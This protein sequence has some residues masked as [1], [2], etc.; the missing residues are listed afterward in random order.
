MAPSS[1]RRPIALQRIAASLLW[2]PAVVAL[3]AAAVGRIGF[4]PTDEGMVLAYANR[5]LAGQ[6]PHRDFITPRPV[7]ASLLHIVDLFAPAPLVIRSHVIALAEMTAIAILCG[8]LVFRAV[9][10]R[11]TLP[12]TSLVLAVLVV[13]IHTFP[14][15]EWSTVDGVLL[16]LVGL[17]LLR[18]VSGA[19]PGRTRRWSGLLVAGAA[20]TMKQSF[21]LAPILAAAVAS[22]PELS[23]GR[24]A[25]FRRLLCSGVIAATPAAMYVG[26]L[27]ALGAGPAMATQLL[28][29]RQIDPLAVLGPDAL[30]RI[31]LLAG[32][33]AAAVLGIRWIRRTHPGW[34]P[35]VR[36]AGAIAELVSCLLILAAGRLSIAGDWG[37]ELVQLLLVSTV[38][39]VLAGGRIN[40][41]AI[42][43]GAIAWMTTLSY[44]YNNADLV[45]G[46]VALVVT[47]RAATSLASS[48][49]NWVL[50]VGWRRMTAG[51]AIAAVSVAAA[52]AARTHEVYR[53][54][55][56]AQLTASA[57][58]I[59]AL[60]GIAIDPTTQRYL[61]DVTGCIRRYAAASVAVLPDNQILYLALGIH[62]PFPIDWMTPSD[63]EGSEQRLID[64]ARALDARGGYLVLF[65]TIDATQLQNVSLSG[66]ETRARLAA[67]DPEEP[68][69]YAPGVLQRVRDAL[70]GR[71]VA[72]GTFIGVYAP[73]SG[74]P[75][76]L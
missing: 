48:R 3:L 34:E 53:D 54:P 42:L 8:V 35:P 73:L 67:A 55:P 46:C 18:P 23:H 58:T 43:V 51:V 1:A 5:I 76:P 19:T 11:W 62:N 9:P 70:H 28:S 47:W 37:D 57:T 12:Q 27:T 15:M 52:V 10:P 36:V 50:R 29:Q 64:A 20:L 60:S 26:V 71:L 41:A 7:G 21:V 30:T 68:L 16:T 17:V 4:N 66:Y 74:S 40:A 22:W 33:A 75:L 61:T 45:A 49:L 63:Y 59:P 6:V 72:C 31:S 24:P 56:A 25:F 13:N 44:G 65:Q 38:I 39:R 2:P 32:V 69:P 14:L